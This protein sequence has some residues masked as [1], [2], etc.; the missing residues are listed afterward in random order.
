[1][2]AKEALER[3]IVLWDWLAENPGMSKLDGLIACFGMEVG[4]WPLYNCFLCESV[5]RSVP[6]SDRME[7]DCYRCPVWTITDEEAIG[8]ESEASPYTAWNNDRFNS[9]AAA[10]VAVLCRK[11]LEEL[12]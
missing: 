10:E 5:K 3:S 6:G 4:K 2:N 12:E 7:A 8:C 11:A 1:M 9:T